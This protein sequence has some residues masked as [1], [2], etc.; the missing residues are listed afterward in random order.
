LTPDEL[1]ATESVV[2]KALD[3]VLAREGGFVDI[4]EDRGGPT[5]HGITAATLGDWRNLHRP[6]TAEEVRALPLY[7]AR[8]IL[9]F[10]YYELSGADTLLAAPDALE[11]VLDSAVQHGPKQAARFLQRAVGV[12]D[13]GIVGPVTR[14]AVRAV[15]SD[16]LYYR[17]LA[18]R[19]RF[20]GRWITNDTTDA[21]RDG[22][23]DT[24]E[25]AAGLLAR[26][27]GFIER[28]LLESET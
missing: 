20:L 12:K 8:D 15:F 16:R 11:L 4:P 9:R 7:E 21:D 2:N 22:V 13:D 5:N 14:R 24:A 28:E 19:V 26:M 10:R 25:L 6:A 27:A 17:V 3:G 18:E 23:T 1:A